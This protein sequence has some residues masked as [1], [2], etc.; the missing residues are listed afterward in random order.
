[1]QR[2]MGL[3][4]GKTLVQVSM[5]LCL[6]EPRRTI[7]TDA[8]GCPT[9]RMVCRA[10]G[11]SMT[12]GPPHSSAARQSHP[13]FTSH[14]AATRRWHGRPTGFSIRWMTDSEAGVNVWRRQA[15]RKPH[16]S[17]L[18]RLIGHFCS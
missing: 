1:M 4:N 14:A 5:L 12:R 11:A 9:K 2:I 10:L 7:W 13:S 16:C 3:F 18:I 15:S 6:D 8:S 17:D